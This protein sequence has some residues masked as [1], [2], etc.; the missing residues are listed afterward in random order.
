[1]SAPVSVLLAILGLFVSA[2]IRLNGVI[3]G[4]PVSVSLLGLIS[5]VLVLTLLA[6]VLW[7]ARQVI[8]EGGL[9]LRFRTV[10]T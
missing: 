10:T 6:I 2:R 4:Q 9:R 5:A 1:M 3:F 7:L 8:R